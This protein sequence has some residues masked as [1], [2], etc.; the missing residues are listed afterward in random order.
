LDLAVWPAAVGERLKRGKTDKNRKTW[1]IT[2]KRMGS[3][4]NE[5]RSRRRV[6]TMETQ[7]NVKE[8]ESI[9]GRRKKGQ[10][11]KADGV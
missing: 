8:K 6:G 4:E 10:R 11:E 2:E 7:T 1:K 3:V 5:E 9:G